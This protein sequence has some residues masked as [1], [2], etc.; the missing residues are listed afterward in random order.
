MA[1][2]ARPI[3]GTPTTE[4]PERAFTFS[5]VVAVYN[6]EEYLEEC[7]ESV[8]AQ[9]VGFENIQLILVNDGSQ[10]GSLAICREYEAKYPNNVVV[11]DKPNGGVSSA[12]N[13]GLELVKGAYVNF[14]DSDDKWSEDSFE[15]ALA[16]F[17]EH[18]EVKLAA[19]RYLMFGAK[20]GGHRLNFK[21]TDDRVIDL[22]TEYDKPQLSSS[23]CFFA[24]DAVKDLRFS[25]ELSV[26]EDVLLIN[27]LLLQELR[28]GVMK[29]TNYYYRQHEVKDSAVDTMKQ[30]RSWYFD[31]TRLCSE[32]LFEMSRER[33]GEVLPFIQFTVMYDMQWRLRARKADTLTPDELAE[34]RAII[35]A[36]LAQ[37]DDAIISEQRTIS[38]D[39]VAYAFSLKYGIPMADILAGLELDGH[40][41][42]SR[43]ADATGTMH[44]LR[45]RDIDSLSDRLMIESITAKDDTLTLRGYIN[46]F[47]FPPKKVRLQL[48]ANNHPIEPTM[49]IDDERPLRIPF[50]DAIPGKTG[51]TAKV[52]LAA[53]CIASIRATMAL[54]GAYERGM[55]F[56]FAN[57]T[58]LNEAKKQ[59]E[60]LL[61]GDTEIN[62]GS[63][64]AL[65]LRRLPADADEAYREKRVALH[66]ARV[67]SD[68]R[69]PKVK[70][71]P[72]AWLEL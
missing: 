20:T 22:R 27:T 11:V 57:D 54:L 67:E 10:D 49:H 69:L 39:Y 40:T 13:A 26:S 16:F 4:T 23:T 46:T 21:F 50:D 2:H 66:T 33:Y 44:T 18:P 51:F 15:H 32:A 42:V 43:V 63:P 6:A 35:V 17:E 37:I 61:V 7:V 58:D 47:R 68:K 19:S 60:Y 3:E 64:G 25:E 70:H 34:Y 14:L 59:G 12:R 29:D 56:D 48:F 45:L 9:T 5:V 8:I 36:L 62:I 72:Q 55:S 30:N 41:V 53:G 24:A 28:Y 71:Q 52:T 38:I 65:V 1:K 31:T